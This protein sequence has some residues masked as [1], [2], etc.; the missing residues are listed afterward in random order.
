M[1][2]GLVLL[3]SLSIGV[4]TTD[5]MSQI[6][7]L[8]SDPRHSGLN[9]INT[10]TNPG[11]IAWDFHMV[12]DFEYGGPVL[13][14]SVAKDGNIYF[15]SSFGWLY[16]LDRNGSFLWKFNS[17]GM[18]YTMPVIGIDGSVLFVCG[19]GL[20]GF[21]SIGNLTS[22]F[23]LSVEP[24]GTEQWRTEVGNGTA[25]V[26]LISDQGLIYTITDQAY[27][28]C[29]RSDGTLLWN[30][31]VPDLT[32]RCT[33]AISGDMIF[34]STFSEI[35]KISGSDGSLIS[36]YQFK[37]STVNYPTFVSIGSDG[38]IYTGASSK[39]LIALTSDLI[40]KWQFVASGAVND[41]PAIGKDGT[42]YIGS[43]MFYDSNRDGVISNG[44]VYAIAPDG[45][46]KWSVDVIGDIS[47][48]VIVSYDDRIYAD[49][50]NILYCIDTNGSLLWTS[51][52]FS[53]AEQSFQ[54]PIPLAFDID[55]SVLVPTSV[56][57]CAYG[58]GRPC[59]PNNAQIR[60]GLDQ[61]ELS[62]SYPA[63]GGSTVTGYV[64]QRRSFD[65]IS[66]TSESVEINLKGDSLSYIDRDINRSRGYQYSIAS[67]NFNGVGPSE[68]ITGPMVPSEPNSMLVLGV[69]L[70]G[71]WIMVAAFAIWDRRKGHSEERP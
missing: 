23:L 70:V 42:L 39:T 46:M 12:I 8:Q 29:I 5:G 47:S 60:Y 20:M 1:I 67:V 11:G 53:V 41:A 40:L 7:N 61:N 30:R 35:L 44:N 55:G 48:T 65:P 31:L 62:W 9:Q 27:I 15:T 45:K 19:P 37:N 4:S 6:V 51:I 43:M 14:A 16:A 56:G 28:S 59:S 49:A 57:L 3:S 2:V 52:G 32:G 68:L 17:N 54:Q 64:L 50:G 71:I 21:L 34:V 33:P 25:G 58:P 18:I 36:S 66:Q 10:S 13:G 24:N 22:T 26:P 38:T 69:I 63:D